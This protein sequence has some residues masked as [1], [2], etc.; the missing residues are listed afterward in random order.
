MRR[1][2]VFRTCA[3]VLRQIFSIG[4]LLPDG[5][6]AK[7]SD[8]GFTGGFGHFWGQKNLGKKNID[9]MKQH[10]G[11]QGATFTLILLKPYDF[12]NFFNF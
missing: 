1:T 2:A 6:E 5:K 8:N 12:R 7:A 9:K 11:E 10:H 3:R 4:D